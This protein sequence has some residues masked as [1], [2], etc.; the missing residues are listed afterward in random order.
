MVWLLSLCF[1][2]LGFGFVIASPPLSSLQIEDGLPLKASR[3]DKF[4]VLPPRGTVAP[5]SLAKIEELVGELREKL[6]SSTPAVRD[7]MLGEVRLLLGKP[8]GLVFRR[9]VRTRGS[10]E[11][12]TRGGSTRRTKSTREKIKEK[13][14]K[15]RKSGCCSFFFNFS[16]GFLLFLFPA[17]S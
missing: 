10:D 3:I 8:S 1:F 15:K 4:W 12:K 17:S 14:R 11:F 2:V 9:G 5:G 6:V 7:E 16:H 13:T